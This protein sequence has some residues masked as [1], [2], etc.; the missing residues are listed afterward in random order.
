[1]MAIVDEYSSSCNNR[2]M[3]RIDEWRVFVTVAT[4]KSFVAAA[5]AHGRSAQAITRAIAAL[6]ARLGTRLF[7]RTTRAV[8]I[9][10]DGERYLAQARRVLPEIDILEGAAKPGEIAGRLSITA[11]VL[12]GQ[13]HVVP[14]VTE[15]MTKQPALDARLVLLDRV[16]S[17]ADEGIDVAVRIGELPDSS[18]RARL[19]G[20]VRSIVCASPAYLERAGTPRTPDALAKH[21]C[22]STSAIPDRWSF[23]RRSIVIRARLV[24]NSNQSAI[25]AAIAGLGVAR[26]MSYQIASLVA[27]GQ[28]R[29][30]LAAHEPPPLPVQLLHLPGIQTR[31]AEA[32]AELATSMLTARLRALP[33]R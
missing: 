30:L 15:L 27:S 18:L 4:G 31:A 12:F 5:R 9:T 29:V 16:V 32:F 14:V 1:M 7:H 20:H 13:L 6:E 24:T 11:P 26:V 21:P 10:S 8:S 17:L 2:H 33:S 28:L 22:I 23:G 25:D 3:D 19:V